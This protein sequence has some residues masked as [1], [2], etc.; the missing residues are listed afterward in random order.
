MKLF[1]KIKKILKKIIKIQIKK[2]KKRGIK[3]DWSP[4]KTPFI[5]G[6]L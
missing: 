5:I 6:L 2:Q 1:F 3:G 4:F